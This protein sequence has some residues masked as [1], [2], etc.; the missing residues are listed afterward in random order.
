[1]HSPVI[2]RELIGLEGEFGTPAAWATLWQAYSE[3][4]YR[5][6]ASIVLC[7]LLLTMV[8]IDCVGLV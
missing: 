5:L 4:K 6:M 7:P 3:Q 2:G 8:G 1:M